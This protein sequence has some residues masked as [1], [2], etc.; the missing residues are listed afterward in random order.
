MK[1]LS[2]RLKNI[3]SLKG[4]WKIDF[5]Q[6]PFCDSG[7]FAITGA[8][9][10]GKTTLLDAVCLAL[11]HKT[12]RLNVSPT[13]NELMT[14]HTA[15]S[16]AEVEFEVKG[17]G[18]RAFWSQRKAKGSAE[19]NLQAPKVELAYLSDG[20][21]ITDKV[22]DKIEHIA[23]ITGLDF[24]RF[25]KSMMLS[26]GEFAAFLNAEP[27][28]RAE[29]LEEL[30]GTEI[31]GLV[32]ERVFQAH[33]EAKA[34]LDGLYAQLGGV[35]LLT[36]DDRLAMELQ[37]NQ[38]LAQE[39]ELG[40]QIAQLQVNQHWLEKRSEYAQAAQRNQ[41]QLNQAQQQLEQHQSSLETLTQSLPAEKLRPMYTELVRLRQEQVDIDRD[42]QQTAN[43]QTVLEQEVKQRSDQ[44][45]LTMQQR[46]QQRKADEQTETLMDKQVAPL[47]LQISRRQQDHRRL[48]A[49][50]TALQQQLSVQRQSCDLAR[51]QHAD[52][53]AQQ[54]ALED[55]FNSHQQRQGL[56]ENLPLW[57]QQLSQLDQQRPALTALQAQIAQHHQRLARLNL[58]LSQ[59]TE[60]QTQAQAE[61]SSLQQAFKLADEQ[62]AQRLNQQ[63]LTEL[64]RQR[65]SFIERRDDHQSLMLLH[66]R[67]LE[68]DKTR[69]TQIKQ[70]SELSSTL[71]QLNAD[72]LLKRKQYADKKQHLADLKKLY[73]QEKLIVGFEQQR[74]QLQPDTPCPLCGSTQHPLLTEYQ[75]VKPSDTELRLKQ[76][77]AETAQM[78][79][80]GTEQ[81]SR[82]K[83]L[84]EQNDRLQQ[85]IELGQ[86]QITQLTEQWQ[87]L[88]QRLELPLSIHESQQV[89]AYTEALRLQEQ[90]INQRVTE[91]EQSE[92]AWLQAKE[93][94]NQRQSALSESGQRLTLLTQNIT[95]LQQNI[96]QTERALETQQQSYQ[97]LASDLRSALALQG[98]MLPEAE[99][100]DPWLNARK[101]EWSHWQTQLAERQRLE[102]QLSQLN[103]V[104]AADQAR[105]DSI[106]TQVK[107]LDDRAALC[108]SELAQISLQRHD[109]F[110][111]RQIEMVQQQMRQRRQ[112]LE[113]Q[114]SDGQK[115]WMEAN[116]RL[117][118]LVAQRATLTQQSRSKQRARL[119][120]ENQFTLALQTTPFADEA[121]FTA[122]LLTEEQR[123]RLTE[124]KERLTTELT[125]AQTL[126]TEAQNS[127]NQHVANPPSE[128]LIETPVDELIQRL[129]SLNSALK[130]NGIRQGEIRQQ[131][132]SDRRNQQSQQEMIANIARHQQDVDDLAYLNNLIGSSDGAKFRK[133]AQ[134]LTLD[135]LVYLANDQ[136][137]RLHGRYLLQRK[138]SETLELQVVDTW[139]ADNIRDTR[140]LSGGESFLVS[141]ALALA[142][143]DLVSHKTS[144]D[145]LF[146]DEGFGTLD[147]ETLDIALD[148]LDNLNASGKTIG[149]IS[150]I[151]AMK[152]RIPVQIRVK[153]INGL[154]ISKL[155]DRYK[156]SVRE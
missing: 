140:T 10:A 84:T 53:L 129:A 102:Q 45:Q 44:Y 155:D 108:Q 80:D 107:E 137:A 120:C 34:Q 90:Q 40:R 143:S 50:Q 131:Q 37:V 132:E 126:L 133:F 48:A 32:S 5:T 41:R 104:M 23:K 78:H 56:G 139:Q 79:D 115:V 153:K 54:A 64:K 66:Q 24:S 91:L 149:V 116:D 134:G 147:A 58:E 92:K 38:L 74:A 59:A 77:E 121:A 30:T 95:H 123:Q 88:C 100:H 113:Q 55:F 1:I 68:A 89:N 119:D 87:Q 71:K 93:R 97:S 43:S 18:Y 125:R 21:I 57:Q 25:T 128:L 31:Y 20:K 67:Y 8:T 17:T 52:L 117:T 47:D 51:K 22:K 94:L 103:A 12:P 135:H 111:D 112:L 96:E 72:Q 35:R 99:Q 33:K 145:S 130:D 138:E 65:D 46:D 114:L 19:G 42:L 151:D 83:L 82:I 141:L 152:E 2:L 101:Q 69:I 148:A 122:A 13:H 7:L 15:E 9:G 26:Q 150:H 60:S 49:E 110:G 29:L 81:G 98:L 39:T 27:N 85:D 144:I 136:L 63:D 75:A 70:L 28:E 156:V 36:D 106:S 4:E 142:L 154:G 105:L 14:H 61:I 146:L 16:L 73:E 6:E 62:H 11:Y 127:L 3:N 124:L 118:A 76:L 109:I 86:R